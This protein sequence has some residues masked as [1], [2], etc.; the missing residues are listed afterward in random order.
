M[1]VTNVKPAPYWDE[2]SLPKFPALRRSVD[3]D[4]VV[5]G[6][7]LTGITSALLLGEAG[8]RVALVERG[9]VGG[10]DTGCTSA[11][12][13][14]VVDA[15]FDDLVSRL[16]RDHAQ[17][18]WDAGLAAIATVD[19]T[20]REHE[21]DGFAWVD[22]YLHAPLDDETKPEITVWRRMHPSLVTSDSIASSWNRSRWLTGQG[23]MS[24]IRRVCSPACTWRASP[25]RSSR[26]AA[27]STS[28]R[29]LTSSAMTRGQ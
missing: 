6:G 8:L 24:W 20:V 10:I 1:S 2:V 16:G 9:K 27:T 23:F 26:W 17:A 21:I 28:T 11:H 5:V 19:E 29:P 22:G 4:V 25:R 18:V 13:T 14:C 3:A 7:G 12:L 15:H